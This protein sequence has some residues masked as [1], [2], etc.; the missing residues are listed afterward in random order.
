M[1][2]KMQPGALDLKRAAKFEIEKVVVVWQGRNTKRVV[3]LLLDFQP[4]KE[5]L[6]MK[7]TVMIAVVGPIIEA[8]ESKFQV[9]YYLQ[10]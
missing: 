4:N 3:L 2:S 9:P 5:N 8:G 10:Q 1:L 7:R 6:S